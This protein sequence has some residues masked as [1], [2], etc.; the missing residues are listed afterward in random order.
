VDQEFRIEPEKSPHGPVSIVMS[1]ADQ[2]VLVMRSGVEIGRARIGVR[3]PDQPL[4]THAYVMTADLLDV[5]NPLVPGSRMPKWTAIAMPG[6]FDEAGRDLSLAA[7]ERIVVPPGFARAVHM[8]LA[9]GATLFVTDAPIL[10]EH[11]HS[12]ITVLSTGAPDATG[13]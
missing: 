9:P 3:N 6:H 12:D 11:V 8:L 5:E 2:R 10:A 13:M 7:S 4:G 1:A